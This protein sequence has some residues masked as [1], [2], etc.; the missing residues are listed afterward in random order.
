MKNVN[1][2]ILMITNAK[3]NQELCLVVDKIDAMFMA[4]VMEIEL[5]DRDWV[6]ITNL[7]YNHKHARTS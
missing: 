2:A 3:S 4:D 5:S 1:D 6:D 7:I